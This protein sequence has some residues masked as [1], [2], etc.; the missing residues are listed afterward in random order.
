M[1]VKINNTLF[2]VSFLNS[3]MWM[4]YADFCTSKVFFVL[5]IFFSLDYWLVC[6]FKYGVD[7][8]NKHWYVIE[9]NQV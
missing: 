3:L 6:L 7:L 4:L 9:H 8:G 2:K 1:G 5:I